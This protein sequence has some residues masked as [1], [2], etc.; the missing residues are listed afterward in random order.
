MTLNYFHSLKI[1]Q[2]NKDGDLH[3]S[4]QQLEKR[5]S[6]ST[7]DDDLLHRSLWFSPS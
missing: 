7:Q 5:N 3:L 2:E 6:P 1:V 4:W